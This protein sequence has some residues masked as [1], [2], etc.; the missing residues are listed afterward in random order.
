[1]CHG[2]DFRLEH[3]QREEDAG[4]SIT[5]GDYLRKLARENAQKLIVFID[6]RFGIYFTTEFA[7]LLGQRS[8]TTRR[9]STPPSASRRTR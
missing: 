1:M 9:V 7:L 3:D 6:D 5:Q 2:S 4:R 8:S